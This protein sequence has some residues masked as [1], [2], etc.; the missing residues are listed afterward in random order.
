MSRY[1]I[2]ANVLLRWLESSDPRHTTVKS[3]M[4]ALEAQGHTLCITAQNIIEFWAVASR[5]M[6]ANGFGW[7]LSRC[8]AAVPLLIASFEFLP[9]TAAVFEE[10]RRLVADHGVSSVQ[11]HDTRLVAV[12]KAHGIDGIL[13]FNAKHFRRFTA[14]EG[15]VIVDPNE[16]PKR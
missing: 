5:P 15:I 9:D 14:G 2:D 16:N 10:W 12:M 6:D 7:D 1:L 8:N 11:V 13:T 4:M 3:A